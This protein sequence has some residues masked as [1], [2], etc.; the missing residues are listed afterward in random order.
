[1]FTSEVIFP[2]FPNPAEFL[3]S[4]EF[5]GKFNKHFLF[6]G[7]PKS[8]EKGKPYLKLSSGVGSFN[9]QHF[10]IKNPEIQNLVEA[11]N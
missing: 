10:L 8:R 5:P 9:L 2:I 6:P 3:G 11:A 4:R 7:K 1:L